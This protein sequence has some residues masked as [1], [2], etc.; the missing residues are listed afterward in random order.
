MA[1]IGLYYLLLLIGML[2]GQVLLVIALSKIQRISP[3]AAL[4]VTVVAFF[5]VCTIAFGVF[6]LGLLTVLA[7]AGA[8]AA[9]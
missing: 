7:V 1:S 4:G 5:V 3:G 6:V 9:H 2:W 8:R